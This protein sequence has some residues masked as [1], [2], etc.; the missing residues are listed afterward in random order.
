MVEAGS[1]I[2]VLVEGAFVGCAGDGMVG[3]DGSEEG[4]ERAWVS[5]C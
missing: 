5:P 1:V 2:E 3:Y 4:K